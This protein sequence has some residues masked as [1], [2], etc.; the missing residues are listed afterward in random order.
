MKPLN[1]LQLG[2]LAAVGIVGNLAALDLDTWAVRSTT[3]TNIQRRIG[4]GNG[5]FV[6]VGDAGD[7]FTSTT[8]GHLWIKAD[9]GTTEQLR[10]LGSG[11]GLLV[12]VGRQGAVVTSSDGYHWTSRASGTSARL[13]DVAH[14]NGRFVVVDQDSALIL[15]SSDGVSWNVGEVRVAGAPVA[16]DHVA[17][18][19]GLF[20]GTGGTTLAT[21]PKTNVV[22][23]ADGITWN[24]G[25]WPLPQQPAGPVAYGNGVFV[26]FAN[27]QTLTF[28]NEFAILSSADGATWT[29][30][31]TGLSFLPLD[32]GVAYGSGN[33]VINSLEGIW[34]ST[35]GIAWVKHLNLGAG[36]DIAFG[37]G[38]FV[39][40]AGSVT[41]GPDSVEY[42]V[43][44]SGEPLSSPLD[45]WEARDSGVNLD[46]YDVTHALGQFVAVG[47][48]DGDPFFGE[49]GEPVI[50]T[51][52]NGADWTR[53]SSDGFGTLRSIT[54]GSGIYAAVG[55]REWT[56]SRPE[57][58][59][60]IL[61][62][63]DGTNWARQTSGLNS[64]LWSIAYGDGIFVAVGE[65]EGVDAT[66]PVGTGRILT[67]SDGVN[68]IPRAS[69]V[70][71]DLVSVTYG[72]GRFVAV[73]IAGFDSLA[74]TWTGVVLISSDGTSWNQVSLPVDFIS[75]DGVAF[76]N[77]NFIATGSYPDSAFLPQGITMVSTDGISW[78]RQSYSPPT[79]YGLRHFPGYF[80]LLGF[81]DNFLSAGSDMLDASGVLWAPCD[82]DAFSPDAPPVL[83]SVAGDGN[84]VVAVGAGGVILQTSP[85]SPPTAPF[86]LADAS[87]S[88]L[89]VGTSTLLFPDATLTTTGPVQ[90]AGGE[91]KLEV[92]ANYLERVD[93]LTLSGR[94]E[95]DSSSVSI[96]LDGAATAAS[97]QEAIRSSEYVNLAYTLVFQS[98][99]LHR[100]PDRQFTLT[101]TD[102][103]G[104]ASMVVKTVR[105]NELI[106]ID[107]ENRYAFVSYPGDGCTYFRLRGHF[108][109]GTVVMNEWLNLNLNTVW[110]L[111]DGL[112]VFAIGS[113]TQKKICAP[114][115]GQPGDVYRVEVTYGSFATEGFLIVEEATF[116]CAIDLLFRFL[117][118]GL[119]L[120]SSQQAP[121][122]SNDPP[123]PASSVFHA[124]EY[125]MMQTGLGQDWVELYRGHSAE[126]VEIIKSHQELIPDMIGLL[127]DFQP[128]VI[129]LLSGTGNDAVITQEM[130]DRLNAV[131]DQLLA[132]ASPDLAQVL[133][134]ERARFHGFQDFVGQG[135]DRWARTLGLVVPTEPFVFVSRPQWKDGR[136]SVEVNQVDGL[137]YS[138]WSSLDL[139]PESWQPV[140]TAEVEVNGPTVRFTDPAATSNR[141][142]YQVRS[143][144]G[145]MK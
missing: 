138:L 85:E 115:F 33:F 83:Y 131:W 94:T 44:V 144:A 45:S 118:L 71:N 78:K 103:E 7:I 58:E 31:A 64:G 20:I 135:F 47:A 114:S 65:R 11:N 21:D 27:R 17:F 124:L 132:Y 23:S 26:T 127:T 74:N 128:L 84:S 88:F 63:N 54:H 10:G 18:G 130:I 119:G 82:P 25:N 4:F 136:F 140:S 68:W 129:A 41:D 86:S 38:A 98:D 101:L 139:S 112:T 145:K 15:T 134:T 66:Q 22:I 43:L 126:V 141:R 100:E 113:S 39:S 75:F 16:V 121:L 93:E 40:L 95:L 35:D 123:P 19:G 92:T 125:L 32:G 24:R 6:A 97:V 73:G 48:R 72:S 61:I 42:G 117:S 102:G 46:L 77:G 67:S 52:N 30:R 13:N 28:E 91:I 2:I 69:G 29:S 8:G 3:G 51:S 120:E 90:W 59:A 122:G 110:T 143:V 36:T 89:F 133:E 56:N 76:G 79:G 57:G 107:F 14:G 106:G 81:D 60:L 34:T 104:H 137:T 49:T 99:P 62:S 108:A 55:D 111:L 70:S 37:D 80:A 9:S 1:T 105:F 12:A 96:S 87:A 53:Q 116:R 142:F 5:A 50:L 109:D